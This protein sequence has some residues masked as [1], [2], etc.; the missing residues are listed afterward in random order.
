LALAW[1]D[2]LDALERRLADEQI[3]KLA[4]W[5][6]P[7]LDGVDLDTLRKNRLALL[8]RIQSAKRRFR[9]IASD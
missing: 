5:P 1:L 2:R 9:A 7:C 3:A 6:S 8:D 4:R